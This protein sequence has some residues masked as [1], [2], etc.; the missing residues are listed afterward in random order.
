MQ[1]ASPSP[2][3]LPHRR[4]RPHP[5]P[6]DCL[7][8][9]G[10]REEQRAFFVAHAPEGLTIDDLSTLGP[11][12]VLKLKSQPE[13]FTRPLAIE[14]WMYPDGSRLLELS[15]RCGP[16]DADGTARELQRFLDDHDVG[17]GD[18]QQ[19]KTRAALAIFAAELRTRGS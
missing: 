10:Y 9:G 15:A 8:S 11:S 14:M 19:T 12:F 17:I 4:S 1:T 6:A 16:D 13:G 7:G 5:T 2:H 3:A 18:E